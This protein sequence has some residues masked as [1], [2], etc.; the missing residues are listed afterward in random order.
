MPEDALEGGDQKE[1]LTVKLSLEP[2]EK[3]LVGVEYAITGTAT[4]DNYDVIVT[5]GKYT[6]KKKNITVTVSEQKVTYNGE[7][8]APTSNYG[9]DWTVE[10]GGLVL[11]DEP[12]ALN[13]QLTV[14][15]ECKNAKSYTIVGSS[16]AQNYT[17]TFAGDGKFVIEKKNITIT[18]S[19]VSV[20][21][22][23]T[24]ELAKGQLKFTIEGLYEDGNDVSEHVVLEIESFTEGAEVGTT[25]TIKVSFG[26]SYTPANYTAEFKEGKLTVTASVFAN[27][28]FE[29]ATEEYDGTLHTL[30]ASNLP[31]N[32]QPSYVYLKDGQTLETEGV[33]NAGTYQ[34]KLT[35][36]LEGY[37]NYEKTVNF[38]ISKRAIEISADTV[39]KT[40][41]EALLTN[42][43]LTFTVADGVLV[44]GDTKD[45]LSVSLQWAQNQNVGDYNITG[46]ATAENYAVT[47]KQGT[48]HIAKKAI[49]VTILKQTWATYSGKV[50]NALSTDTYWS[51]EG[52]VLND[53]KSVLGVTLSGSG[54]DAKSYKITG[55]ANASNYEVSF[56]GGDDAFVIA[57]KSIE[58]AVITVTEENIIYKAE[59]WK[60][61]FT[62]ALTGFDSITFTTAYGE[63]LNAGEDAGS[64]TI[65]GS[66]NFT[67]SVT[68]TFD[69]AQKSIADAV[70][71]VTEESIIYKDEQWRPTFT[72]VL[73]GFN[74]FT[75]DTAYGDNVNAGEGSI[76]LTGSGNFSGTAT[77]NFTISPATIDRAEVTG[78][79]TY[80]GKGVEATVA[81]SAGELVGLRSGVDFTVTYENN[82]NAGEGALAK[83]TGQG[84]Y[85]GSL[86]ATFTIAPKNISEAKVTVNGSYVYSGSAIVPTKEEVTVE[87]TGFENV[88]F[89]LSAESNVSATAQAKVTVTGTG[90]YCGSVQ[91]SFKISP[92]KIEV[93][94]LAQTF[95]YSGSIP[96]PDSTKFTVNDAEI[97]SQNGKKDDLGI[98]ISI[99]NAAAKADTYG[100]TA[101][102]ANADYEV[103]FVTALLT[104]TKKAITV[105]ADD[106]TAFYGDPVQTL[107]FTA[108][109]VVE[110]EDPAE[111]LKILLHADRMIKDAGEYTITGSGSAENY[112]I[113]VEAGTYTVKPKEIVI[114]I[115]PQSHLYDGKEPSVPAN[116]WSAEEGA[117]LEGDNLH[118]SLKKESGVDVKE[119]GY[120]ITGE[121]T[122][123]NYAVTFV[124][125]VYTITPRTIHVEIEDQSAVYNYRHE[126]SLN[127]SRWRIAES[128]ETD[129]LIAGETAE[130]LGVTL[131]TDRMTDAGSYAIRGT[132][133]NQNYAV[134]FVGGYLSEDADNGHAGIYSISQLDISDDAIFIL[135]IEGNDVITETMRR[136]RT[137][138]AGE[139]LTLSCQVTYFEGDDAHP[140]GALIS[141]ATIEK[142][143]DYTVTV[144]IQDNNYRG[145][146][147]FTVIVTD[148]DGYTQRL[149]DTLARLEEIAGDLTAEELTVEDFNTVKE[150][151]TLLSALDETERKVAGNKLDKYESLV[152]GWKELADLDEI[153][154]TA[155]TI[156]DAPIA[157]LL[158]TVAAVSALAAL[159]YVIRKGGLL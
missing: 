100:L 157:A 13:V 139:T 143:G 145:S 24:A 124:Q 140:L 38:T 144:T 12:S 14:E 114:T 64:I 39:N 107:T 6:L 134:T 104:I 5:A 79:Y 69:I 81:V 97:C 52:L 83:V 105:K 36:V 7:N 22:G 75:Y 44:G 19:D 85:Q 71:T 76:T 82:V 40:Y 149:K 96:T 1:V 60:P 92:K 102:A 93:T 95:E 158:G 98:T 141:P 111:V 48:Y 77:A 43:Q 8:R 51:V 148:A 131:A 122:N 32:A 70:I 103:K 154:E 10:E 87:L 116:A 67:G 42:N 56:T 110:G 65:T 37:K 89:E 128:A 138:F 11:G 137:T 45:V 73:N 49:T 99:L 20:S 57:Q 126:Y 117:I 159:C 30:A 58:S 21:E 80:T 68:V 156:A 135:G 153:I 123:T 115:K 50:Q 33:K 54:T 26:E 112:T 2:A 84:N 121:Y 78:E 127:G 74:S 31:Q 101:S 125:G 9:A 94:L 133:T 23:A 152:E 108:E 35:V 25:F 29:G 150:V 15:G 16:D 27:I 63:N 118:I 132:W 151:G 34:V 41:G 59:Q 86:S 72:A 55:S 53:P 47:V 4:A 46:T 136:I 130:M 109:G 3:Y 146:T 62:A 113:T 66:G 119:G 155:E 142:I 120:A 18:A 106:I 147:Q 17:V 28:T 61:T 90:N 88:T 91:R 129:G